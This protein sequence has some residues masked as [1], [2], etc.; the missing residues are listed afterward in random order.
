MVGVTA[1]EFRGAHRLDTLPGRFGRALLVAL[2]L[3]AAAP[4]A[5]AGAF[6]PWRVDAVPALALDRLDGPAIALDDLRGA[7]VI[8]HFFATWCAP[9]IEEMASLTSLAAL[10]QTDVAIVVVDVGEVDARV[11][12]FFRERPVTFPVLLDRDR[13]AMKAWQ[14]QSLPTSFVLGPNLLP[15]L[16]VEEPLDWGS[17]A[18]IARLSAVS[19]RSNGAPAEP[20]T[21][22]NSDRE[23]MP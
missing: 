19:R 3:T 16:K 21:S 2:S 20:A 14:V 8:V 10:P 17:P 18:V 1:P 23:V 22:E 9:C 4:P 15:A 6:E 12:R 11:R 5:V 7:T 13:A